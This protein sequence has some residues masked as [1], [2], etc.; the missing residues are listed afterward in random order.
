MRRFREKGWKCHVLANSR[1]EMLSCLLLADGRNL[2]MSQRLSNT[3]LAVPSGC[4]ITF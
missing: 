4:Q 2:G 1:Y 3:L